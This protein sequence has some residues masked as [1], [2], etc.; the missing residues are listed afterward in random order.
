M[1]VRPRLK[2]VYNECESFE[3]SEVMFH[4]S[5]GMEGLGSQAG[6]VLRIVID[7]NSIALIGL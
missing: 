1:F 3:L 6:A 7:I 4:E 2:L 5:S